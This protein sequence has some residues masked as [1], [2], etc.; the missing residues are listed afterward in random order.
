MT[1]WLCDGEPVSLLAVSP[2]LAGMVRVGPVY[3]PPEHRGHGHAGALTAAACRR[4][5]D[6]GVDDVVLFAEVANPTS[7][8]L[9]R[10][11]GFEALQERLYLTF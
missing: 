4:A 10:R 2:R 6:E 11:L 1:A 9:Y 3:T 5:L 7:N 8:R